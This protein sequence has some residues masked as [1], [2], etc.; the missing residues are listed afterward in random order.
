MAPRR[1]EE[2]VADSE[3]EREQLRRH[4]LPNVSTT[5]TQSP[6][7]VIELTDDE[8]EI[9]RHLIPQGTKPRSLLVH[10]ASLPGITSHITQRRACEQHP[11][12]GLPEQ[13]RCTS[14]KPTSSGIERTDNVGSNNAGSSASPASPVIRPGLLDSG[15]FDDTLDKSDEDDDGM[16]IGR[17][18][19]TK[20][21]TKSKP[22]VTKEPP[23][24]PQ[25]SIQ[26][27]ETSDAGS[28]KK[29]VRIASKQQPV[30]DFPDAQL[31]K[32]LKC[33]SCDARWTSRKTVAQKVKHILSCAKKTG[34]SDE[35]LRVLIKKELESIASLPKPAAPEQSAS[36][37]K[38]T[39]FE[40]IVKEAAPKR[41]VRREQ[42]TELRPVGEAHDTIRRKAQVVL[43]APVETAEEPA[44][45]QALIA[46]P[47]I[48]ALD[49]PPPTQG[50]AKSSLLQNSTKSLFAF[51][52]SQKSDPPS[53]MEEPPLTQAFAPS[54]LGST[55][56]SNLPSGSTPPKTIPSSHLFLQDTPP[57][58]KNPSTPLRPFTNPPHFSASAAIPSPATRTLHNSSSPLKTPIRRPLLESKSN[59]SIIIIDSDSADSS[60]NE[61]EG[62]LHFDPNINVGM[63]LAPSSHSPS[64]S[65]KQ[66]A[67]EEILVQTSC[68]FIGKPSTSTS[69]K[70]NISDESELDVE[71]PPIRTSP[72]AEKKTR[73]PKSAKDK[74][75]EVEQ[76]YG[77]QWEETIQNRIMQ[78]I[79]LYMRILRYEPIHFD[80]FLQ[81]AASDNSVSSR[82]L[83]PKLRLLLDKMAINFWGAETTSRRRR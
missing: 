78:D 55:R 59:A 83:K 31:A 16:G 17:F 23:S 63:R 56:R 8:D 82:L 7:D 48:Q 14:R 22:K 70:T 69:Q 65:K 2:I 20:T 37:S 9:S 1:E 58:S 41:R 30:L 75:K 81:L 54:K 5:K 53:D 32:L 38:Q 57:I 50:F 49:L 27:P 43:G 45:T 4:A 34:F 21:T 36:T 11:P 40:D 71:I 61:H 42:P 6:L 52:G 33:V 46:R 28:K 77:P 68:P 24:E 72:V 26:P 39:F 76:D 13:T 3:P 67:Y 62:I 29:R 12:S 60:A 64:S 73:K 51:S 74:D 15:F 25:P 80:V 18:A 35:T 44:R 47:T 79:Q 10:A 66:P 19:Y